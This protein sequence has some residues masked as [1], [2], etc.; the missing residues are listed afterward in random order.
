MINSYSD[1][2]D[3]VLV[4]LYYFHKSES[5]YGDRD[6]VERMKAVKREIIR[7]KRAKIWTGP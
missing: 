7:R 6:H 1:V 2:Q 3:D 5:G 4:R